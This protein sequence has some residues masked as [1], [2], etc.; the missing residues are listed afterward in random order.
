MIHF[1]NHKFQINYFH[2]WMFVANLYTCAGMVAIANVL[3]STL[4]EYQDFAFYL[5]LISSTIVSYASS[6]LNTI[7]QF[8]LDKDLWIAVKMFCE[9]KVYFSFQK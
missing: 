9:K 8:Y 7:L 5:Y 6:S 2:Q 1:F 4:P 3:L